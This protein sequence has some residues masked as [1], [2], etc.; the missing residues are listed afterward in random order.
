M[1]CRKQI[2]TTCHSVTVFD[3]AKM[4]SELEQ[5]K[6]IYPKTT[7]ERQRHASFDFGTAP[8]HHRLCLFLILVCVYCEYKFHGSM[9]LLDVS[10]VC[11]IYT[12]NNK[13]CTAHNKEFRRTTRALQ[14]TTENHFVHKHSID[15]PSSSS[16]SLYLS[17]NLLPIYR[18]IF[19]FLLLLFCERP[20]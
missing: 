17:L 20:I 14:A 1:V 7:S 15:S 19:R 18:H 3:S 8:Q 2:G 4:S 12:Y 6:K 11:S 10:R 16:S 9:H 5:R 13:P